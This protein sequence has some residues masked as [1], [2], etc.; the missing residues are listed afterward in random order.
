MSSS[1]H[2]QERP[3]LPALLRWAQVSDKQLAAGG[4]LWHAS[5]LA[6]KGQFSCCS[7]F[8][9]CFMLYVAA[10]S[11]EQ[12]VSG[13]ITR[14][15]AVCRPRCCCFSWPTTS[16]TGASGAGTCPVGA[17][18]VSSVQCSAHGHTS[19]VQ[20]AVLRMGRPQVCQTVLPQHGC[21]LPSPDG[22]ILTRLPPKP[23]PDGM[24]LGAV[25]VM[26]AMLNCSS[27]R[28]CMLAAAA[29]SAASILSN[30]TLC[31]LHTCWA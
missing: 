28:V 19:F 9:S 29:P 22:D 13:S 25:A 30:G 16:P 8:L 20:S 17:A 10:T 3:K 5:G 23:H 14:A 26:P 12:P 21:K 24:A 4:V 2:G 7:C 18:W 15:T 11:H 1:Q 31:C 27:A 6:H